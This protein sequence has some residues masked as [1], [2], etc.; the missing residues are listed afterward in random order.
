MGS[1]NALT[2][3]TDLLGDVTIVGAGAGKT[4]TGFSILSDILSINNLQKR[5][6]S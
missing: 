3:A 5:N 4:E 2:F 6:E 1:T